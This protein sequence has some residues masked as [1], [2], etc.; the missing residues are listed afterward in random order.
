MSD[1]DHDIK[2]AAR[3]FFDA[4][5]LKIDNLKTAYDGAREDLLLAEKQLNASENLLQRKLNTLI[6]AAQAVV[7]N[8]DECTTS[9]DYA[10]FEIGFDY[11]HELQEAI[12]EVKK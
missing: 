11:I 8:A 9:E 2:T 10:G 1:T 4:L 12:I 5:L 7:N 3:D 6:D